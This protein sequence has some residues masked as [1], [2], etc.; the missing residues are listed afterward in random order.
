MSW[1][2]ACRET[3]RAGLRTHSAQLSAEVYSPRCTSN[4]HPPAH[5]STICCSAAADWSAKD[6]G[7][8]SGK[9]QSPA[10]P[11]GRST[12]LPAHRLEERKMRKTQPRPEPAFVRRL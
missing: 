5:L 12:R 7:E 6:R 3:P 1:A 9:D 8:D 10:E 4:G 11:R 2:P